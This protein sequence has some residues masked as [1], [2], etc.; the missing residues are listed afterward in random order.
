MILITSGEYIQGELV[1]EIGYLP[2][3]F[4]P[5]GNR[6]LY[7]FQIEVLKSSFEHEKIYLSVPFDFK[8]DSYDK[9]KLKNLNVEIIFVPRGLTLGNSILYSW[10]A[11]AA[12]H[13]NLIVLHGDTI[14]QGTKFPSTN[15]L[16]VHEN[17]GLYKRASLTDDAFSGEKINDNLSYDSEEVLSGFF[18]F[19][20]PLLFMKF[21]VEKSGDFIEAL[22]RYHDNIGFQTFN[23]GKWLDCGHVNSYYDSRT[24][25]TTQR[26]FND[27]QINRRFVH[28]SSSTNSKK[29]LAE[30]SWYKTL[31]DKLKLHTPPLLKYSTVTDDISYQIEYLYLLPLS[32]LYVFGRLPT[33][34]WSGIFAAVNSTLS[35]FVK[36]SIDTDLVPEVFDKMYLDKTISRLDEFFNESK[37]FS[38]KSTF[39]TDAGLAISLPEM[40]EK[41]SFLIKK[42]TKMDIGICHGDFCFSNI[43]YD[44]KSQSI[45]C[46]DPRG[47]LPD[48][49]ISIFGDKRYDLAKLY[50]SVVGKYDLIIAGRYELV[51]DNDNFSI[52]FPK[53]E[54]SHTNIEDSF[55]TEILQKSGY[56]EKEIL[57]ITVLLF[58]SMLPLHADSPQRQNAFI[59]NAL[60]LYEKLITDGAH[61]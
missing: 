16:S 6:R 3:S 22:R 23:Q 9:E 18:Y 59:F 60:R 27:L 43:L 20:N 11:T 8:M 24:C 34:Q 30:G 53:T 58:L 28:K 48:G 44:S 40:A 38:A 39:K 19:S 47:V 51:T 36:Y 1:A 46:I 33:K 56:E 26:E 32:D 54:N 42:C 7:Q 29:I 5:I 21:L 13:D 61:L 12:Q 35:D 14:I 45:K 57:A 55:R 50:H 4:L 41:V 17:K 49:N 25:I 15:T 31:P 2:P 52:K 37:L 10:N